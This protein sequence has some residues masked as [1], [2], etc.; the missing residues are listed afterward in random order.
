VGRLLVVAVAGA[1]LAGVAGACGGSPAKF[2]PP[3]DCWAARTNA[4]RE[5]SEA[6]DEGGPLADAEE[7]MARLGA[8]R[9]TLQLSTSAGEGEKAG[10]VGFRMEGPFAIGDGAMPVLDLRYTRLLGDRTS[11][12]RVVSTGEVAFVVADGKTIEVPPE[13]AA[14]LRLGDGDGGIA[15]LGIAG[16]ARAPEVEERDGGVRVVRGTVDVADLLSDLARIGEQAGGGGRGEPLDDE[17]AERL[18]RLVES[19]ELVAELGT[20]DLPR[21]LRV[22]VDFAGR[23]P[24]DLREALG[25]YASPRLELTLSLERLDGPLEVEAPER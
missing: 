17:A 23:V 5:A 9:L 20:D 2:Q 10:P 13:E 3:F 21:S 12:T 1:L 22:V 19:S 8:G 24:D 14:R 18:Q 25:A 4:W 16:W 15:D 7:A 6:G 11:E